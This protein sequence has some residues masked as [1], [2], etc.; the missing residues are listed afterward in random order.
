MSCTW[1]AEK[2]RKYPGALFHIVGQKLTDGVVLTPSGKT[3]RCE[4]RTRTPRIGGFWVAPFSNS[5]TASEGHFSTELEP[6][7]ERARCEGGDRTAIT[8]IY[9]ALRSIEVYMIEQIIE[10]KL[11]LRFRSL[12]ETEGLEDRSV[13]VEELRPP[14]LSH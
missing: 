9:A 14:E 7:H 13:R 12:G 4:A 3:D 6:A 5:T 1:K 2:H 11:E 10:L 8:A